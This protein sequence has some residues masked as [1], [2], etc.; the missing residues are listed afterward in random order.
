M[1]M[2][3]KAALALMMMTTATA[4]TTIMTMTTRKENNVHK[5][6]YTVKSLPIVC[7][8]HLFVI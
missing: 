1:T 4:T 3:T 6:I 2:T 7:F 8:P 5:V